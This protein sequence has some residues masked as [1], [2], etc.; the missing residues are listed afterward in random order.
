MANAA[1]QLSPLMKQSSGINAA[2]AEGMYIYDESGQRYMDFTSGIGVTGTGHCHPKVVAAAQKQV[3]T[4]VHGQYAIMKHPPL[5]EMAEKL[6]ERMPEG[7][8]SVFFSNAG[9]EAVEASIRLARQA[10][11]RPNIITF[12]GCFHGRTMGSLSTTTSSVGLRAGVQPIMG[13]V[14][15]APFPNAFRLRMD[16]KTA[17]EHCLRELDNILHTQSAPAETAAMLIEPIQGEA[18]YVPA[19]TEFMKGLREICDRHG[20]LLMMDEVQAGYGRSGLFWGH[21]H[22]DVV[23]DVVISAKGLASGFPLSAMVARPDIMEKG[24]PGSQ[25][26][27]YGGNAVACAAA[28]AT[29]EVY[30]E[31]NLV[32]NAA[33]QGQRLR[34]HLDEIQADNPAIVDVRGKGL[35][36]GT[37]IADADGNPDGERAARI[38]QEAEKRGL[39]M[40]RCGAYGGQIIRWL[41][42]LIVSGDQ[43]DEGVNIFADALKASA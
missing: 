4:L 31:E 1:G 12:Q 19:N 15:V 13:G 20:I 10:T 33:V 36:I 8:T 30:A 3:A 29:L 23:P 41:P 27:T 22:F 39:V 38:L 26:G 34:K 18:G 40:I 17:T 5:L 25:G 7:L 6:G 11:G 43:I 28:L 35:M 42:P 37:E 32:E 14:V 24:W 9:T 2:R 21:Q 16:E